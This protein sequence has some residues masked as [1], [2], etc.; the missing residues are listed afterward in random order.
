[1][2]SENAASSHLECPDAGLETILAFQGAP[3][4]GARAP[5][6]ATKS[7]RRVRIGATLCRRGSTLDHTGCRIWLAKS[8][9]LPPTENRPDA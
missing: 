9:P 1:M 5:R 7:N 3:A 6:K 4:S 8:V 2:S